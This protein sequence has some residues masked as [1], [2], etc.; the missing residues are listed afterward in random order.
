MSPPAHLVMGLGWHQD[1]GV[2]AAFDVWRKRTSGGSTSVYFNRS[3]LEAAISE[4]WAE[5]I[6]VDGPEC[7]FKPD[8]IDRYLSWLLG[9]ARPRLIVADPES[10]S[11]A[12]N[13][14]TLRLDPRSDWDYL[15]LRAGD[16][17]ILRRGSVLLDDCIWKVSEVKTDRQTTGSG[18]NRPFLD[19]VCR[20][21][22]IVRDANWFS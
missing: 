17:L 11:T 22:G 6:R 20:R 8:Q 2:F 7:A 9:L 13:E 3:L 15:A 19:L 12:G 16:H 10:F 18:S 1:Y 14:L 4:D 5:E 21:H